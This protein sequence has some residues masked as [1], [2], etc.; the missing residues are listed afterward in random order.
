MNKNLFKLIKRKLNSAGLP[1]TRETIELVWS[2]MTERYEES[3]DLLNSIHRKIFGPS[4]PIYE[5]KE[6]WS[7]SKKAPMAPLGAGNS[8][9]PAG[10]FDS[11]SGKLSNGQVE[12][13]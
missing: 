6:D 11:F 2:E 4:V 13:E 5:A 9:F 12:M 7:V 8:A 10:Y 1:I 3:M